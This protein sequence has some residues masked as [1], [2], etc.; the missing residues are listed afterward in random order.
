MRRNR[1][2]SVVISLAIILLSIFNFYRLGE[3]DCVKAIQIIS[4]LV[5]G[6]AIGIFLKSLVGI[7]KEKGN[8][9]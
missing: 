6:M 8:K 2:R 9:S 3:T 7:F 5:C 4:L 1:I